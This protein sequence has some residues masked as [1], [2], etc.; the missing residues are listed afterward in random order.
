MS[1]Y[2]KDPRIDDYI[3]S[4]PEWQRKICA[5]VREAIHKANSEIVETI[6]F[7]N[8]PYFVLDGNVCAVLATKT[9]VNVFIYDPIVPDPEGIINQGHGNQTARAIQIHPND[10][11]NVVALKN[12]IQAVATNNKAGGW[13]KLHQHTQKTEIIDGYTVKYHANG[14]TK[15][16]KG[17]V[18]DDQPNGYWEWYRPDGTLKRSGYFNNGEPVGEWTTY[19]QKGAIYKVTNKK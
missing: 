2:I 6:K 11:I 17:K 5:Q 4:L 9:H 7:T 14:K 16:A 15:F 1:Q 19:D 3:N 13:R 8:R 12:L 10:K 18:V